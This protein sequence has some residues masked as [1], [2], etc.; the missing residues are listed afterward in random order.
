MAREDMTQV[1]NSIVSEE[2]RISK[3]WENA[4][5]DYVSQLREIRLSEEKLVEEADKEAEEI[6]KGKR[7]KEEKKL[8]KSLGE[9][10]KKTQRKI[11]AIKPPRNVGSKILDVLVRC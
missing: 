9:E 11:R 1:V 3:K 6:L 2:V 5:H 4:K 7:E 8:E 10:K